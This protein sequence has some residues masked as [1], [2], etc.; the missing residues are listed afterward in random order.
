MVR[1]HAH[2]ASGLGPLDTRRVILRGWSGGAQMVSWLYQ[3]QASSLWS[4][5]CVCFVN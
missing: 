1:Q 2:L 4:V 3:L 5:P